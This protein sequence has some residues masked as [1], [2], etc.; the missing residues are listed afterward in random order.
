M[1]RQDSLG[2]SQYRS[3]GSENRYGAAKAHIQN[4][5]T[6]AG[7]MYRLTASGCR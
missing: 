7:T 5:R 3:T 1:A 4:C 6:L 2:G